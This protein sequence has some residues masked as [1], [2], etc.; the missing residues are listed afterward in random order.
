LAGDRSGSGAISSPRIGQPTLKPRDRGPAIGLGTRKIE[1]EKTMMMA[2][3]RDRKRAPEPTF[4][5]TLRKPLLALALACGALFAATPALAQDACTKADL[6]AATDAYFVAQTSGDATGMPLGQWV[7]YNEQMEEGSMLTGTFSKPL[8]IDFH[9]SIYDLQSCQSFSEVIVADPAHPYVLG[10]VLSL[11]GGRVNT[12]DMLVTDK[13]DWLFNAANTLKYSKAEKWDEI[14]AADRDSRA[15]II[16]AANA[17]LD[18]FNDKSIVVPWGSPCAR[19]EGGLYTAK[20]APGVV[21]PDDTCNVGVPSGTKLVNRTYI[22][23]ES[24]G[25]VTVLLNF[26]GN[27]LPDAHSFRIEKGKIRYVHTITVCK[28]DNCGFKLPPQLQAAIQ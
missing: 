9:R 14:P 28:T 13:G 26:G 6:V 8:K 25:A 11:R 21:S 20:G 22:V 10:T 18:S 15:T 3:G 12:I 1:R 7:K 17:Y 24:L 4:G 27:S 5:K 2:L 19:L 16:A 23:D